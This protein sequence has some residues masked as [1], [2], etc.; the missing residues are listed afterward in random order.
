LTLTLTPKFVQFSR[1]VSLY[2]WAHLNV[3]NMTSNGVVV[4]SAEIT[5]MSSSGVMLIPCITV[6]TVPSF[7]TDTYNRRHM[8]MQD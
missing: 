4:C 6:R 1:K 5:C 3:Y 7:C 8:D 2:R